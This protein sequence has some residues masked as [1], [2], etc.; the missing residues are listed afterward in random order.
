MPWSCC[1]SNPNSI[2]H[3]RRPRGRV[4]RRQHP[5]RSRIPPYRMTGRTIQLTVLAI[6]LTVSS[7]STLHRLLLDSS[8]RHS[9]A[10][11]VA[12]KYSL[13]GRKTH[14]SILTWK[15]AFHNKNT[16]LNISIAPQIYTAKTSASTVRFS[17]TRAACRAL[18]TSTTR[19]RPLSRAPPRMAG[20][21]PT[22]CRFCSSQNVPELAGRVPSVRLPLKHSPPLLLCCVC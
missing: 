2:N 20:S 5:L 19:R 14:I 17:P 11:I 13:S 6:L 16:Y 22:N 7:A 3:S 21:C 15:H 12:W 8:C 18:F 4:S 9:I 1:E 10:S